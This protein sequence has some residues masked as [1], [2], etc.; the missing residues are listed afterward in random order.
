M[1]FVFHYLHFSLHS[2][3]RIPRAGSALH[4]HIAAVNLVPAHDPHPAHLEPVHIQLQRFE[5][6]LELDA[7]IARLLGLVER[8]VH[9]IRNVPLD[10][11]RAIAV[12]DGIDIG[13]QDN[14]RASRPKT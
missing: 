13:S 1:L 11:N 2:S 5:L 7:G 9:D 8:L 6:Q 14:L 3:H 12:G 4:A 10:I